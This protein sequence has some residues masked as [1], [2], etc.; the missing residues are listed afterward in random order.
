M[1]THGSI[2]VSLL[3]LVEQ[4]PT[5]PPPAKRQRG[6]QETYADTLF[7]EALIVMIIR[8]LSTAY[9]LRHF[10]AQDDPVVQR[11]RPLLTEQGHFPT[12]RTWERRCATLPARLPALLGCLGRPL[13]AWLPPW[14]AQG[15]AAAVD[16]TPLRAHGGVWHK[17]P[18]LAG[19]VPHASMD[20]EAAWSTSGS[21]GWWDGWKRHLA[22]SVGAVWLPC[23]LRCAISW[24]TLTIRTRKS[25]PCASR[26]IGRWW[27]P[28]VGPLRILTMAWKC[29]VSSISSVPRPLHRAMACAKTSL[30]GVPRCP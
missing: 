6:R 30:S 24:E 3:W 4:R 18:R 11:I 10:L 12:R 7:V 8:R 13:V 17:T 20:T 19:A 15:H 2:L 14:A 27:R 5:P 25:A 29:G 22:V 21:H 9:A 23:P 1:L 28:G 16:R 26:P